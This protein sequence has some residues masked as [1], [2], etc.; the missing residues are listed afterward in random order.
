MSVDNNNRK[1]IPL[2]TTYHRKL[3][4]LKQVIDKHWNISNIDR[5]IATAFK[6]TQPVVAYRR[7]KNLKDLIGQTTLKNNQ[8]VKN[9]SKQKIGKCQPCLTNINNLC[10][11]QVVD[12]K[13]FTSHQTK[14][15]FDILH[16]LNCRST[17]IIYL[18]QCTLCKLQYVGKSE[19]PF[20]VRLNNHRKDSRN[21]KEDTIPVCKHF[22]ETR[23]NFNTHARFTLIEQIK[24][25]TKSQDE[26]RAI[27][28]RRENFWI[29]KLK[30]L[31]P[32][33]YN[34]ELN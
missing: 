17:F 10:C 25:F 27:L 13:N 2:I 28:L 26:R 21:P 32:Y 34:M 5:N 33:G 3:P 9:C 18:L 22:N 16:N 1:V 31:T 23:H 4:N 30:T 7:N 15:Q 14:Q 12:T 29:T 24:D 19:T 6:H 11:K 20:N 8:V